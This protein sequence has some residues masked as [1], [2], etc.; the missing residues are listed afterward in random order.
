MGRDDPQISMDLSEFMLA[1]YFMTDVEYH[2]WGSG[3]S[4]A[5]SRGV[6]L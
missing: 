2:S 5:A 3:V 1:P 6:G 4:G